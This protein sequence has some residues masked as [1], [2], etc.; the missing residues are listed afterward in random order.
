MMRY[1]KLVAVLSVTLGAFLS[2]PAWATD[3]NESVNGDLSGDRLNPTPITLT[4]GS[5]IITATSGGG[6]LEYYRLFVPGG[7]RLSAIIAVSNT[8]PSLSFIGVQRGTQ[9][10]EDPGAPNVANILGYT[11]FGVGNGTIGTDILDNMGTGAG[12]IGF[13]PPLLP[14]NYTF[15]SQETGGSVTYTLDFQVTAIPNAVPI[16]RGAMGLLAAGLGAVGAFSLL[17]RRRAAA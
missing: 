15:W 7:K 10:T 1:A 14:A 12:A 8:S 5:N 17:R 11:H 16:P 3:W 2:T 9:F 6:D 4:Q 13:V